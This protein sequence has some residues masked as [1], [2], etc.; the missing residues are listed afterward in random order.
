MFGDEWLKVL[1]APA[2]LDPKLLYTQDA[3]RNACLRDVVLLQCDIGPRRFWKRS[4]TTSPSGP[5]RS[6]KIPQVYLQNLPCMYCRNCMES[7]SP[8]R[9]KTDQVHVN[10]PPP[11][12]HPWP[13]QQ[14]TLPILGL[15]D[16]LVYTKP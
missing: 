16:G 11:I 14:P 3:S 10:S 6:W 4:T 1:N 5:A 8:L 2:S 12:R 13:L 7:P 9:Q 15:T